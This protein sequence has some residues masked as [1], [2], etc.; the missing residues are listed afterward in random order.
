[1]N[2][3]GPLKRN[4]IRKVLMNKWQEVICSRCS[5]HGGEEA[6]LKEIAEYLPKSPP[7]T[8][9]FPANTFLMRAMIE[10]SFTAEVK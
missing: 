1:V 5:E 6:A 9:S 3:T 4:Y 10:L 8:G 7:K 2:V